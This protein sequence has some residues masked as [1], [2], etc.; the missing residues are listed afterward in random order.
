M[1]VAACQVAGRVE[2]A[3][4]VAELEHAVALAAG[5]G[6]RL[7]V[8]PEL[9]LSGYAFASRQEV[10]ERAES[11]DGASVQLALRL[12]ATHEVVVVLGFAERAG[13]ELYSSAVVADRGAVLG[14]YRKA[15]LWDREKLF[16]S[17][18]WDGP[19]VL[20]TS[21]GRV[22]VMVCYDLEFPE[23]V[24]RAA[25]A[26]A[27]LLAVPVN[28][29]LL[30]RP[31]GERA[32]E[33]AKAQAAAAG[34]GVTIVVADRCGR[35]RGV[36]WVGGSLVCGPDGYLLAG[37]AT[38]DEDVAAPGVVTA[39]V[40]PGASR[41]KELTELAHRWHDRRPEL[42]TEVPARDGDRRRGSG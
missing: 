4:P 18:G 20:D 26:G 38:V 40:D 3:P 19:M 32:I 15:H 1:T 25:Q 10:Q 23:W 13:D 39:R 6:A 17:A 11:R 8:L 24:R 14:V 27:E 12:S 37:P 41:R 21:V 31:R 36:D 42:Y 34:Y 33:V 35:E 16:F 28:W 9:A 5:R 2:G 22:G 29:P 7:V 30:P